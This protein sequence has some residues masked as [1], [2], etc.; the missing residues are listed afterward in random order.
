MEQLTKATFSCEDYDT[1][2]LMKLLD[3]SKEQLRL[4]LNYSEEDADL[5]RSFLHS[6][7]GWTSEDN[8]AFNC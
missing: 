1:E 3:L 6:E 4:R 7:L 5:V 8:V 2:G